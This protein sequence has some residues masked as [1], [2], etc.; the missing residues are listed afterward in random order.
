MGGLLAR[1]R[2]GH[3]GGNCTGRLRL[4]LRKTRYVRYA[5][6]LEVRNM[7]VPVDSQKEK[8]CGPYVPR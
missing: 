1:G 6:R 8:R 2:H 4:S 5:S 3:D 7:R